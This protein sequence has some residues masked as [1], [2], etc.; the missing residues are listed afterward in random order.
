MKKQTAQD[1]A[2]IAKLKKEAVEL[3]KIL[4]HIRVEN[5]RRRKRNE[6]TTVR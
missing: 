3:K 1:K 4:L 2:R 6:W 5:K